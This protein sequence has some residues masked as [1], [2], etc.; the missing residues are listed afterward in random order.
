MTSKMKWS[1]ERKWNIDRYRWPLEL[2]PGMSQFKHRTF[3]YLP[4]LAG[5]TTQ[6]LN[7]VC[8][9]MTLL[10]NEIVSCSG[11]F[12][13]F[14]YSRPWVATPSPQFCPFS[15]GRPL[16]PF[17][18]SLTQA[19]ILTFLSSG[20]LCPTKS[21]PCADPSETHSCFGC[22][23]PI[24]ADQTGHFAG[25]VLQMRK[26]GDSLGLATTA[27]LWRM[28]ETLTSPRL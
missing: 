14:P 4:P 11:R 21:L 27:C 24:A 10:K 20:Y 6:I 26:K 28:K 16:R 9:I 15:K 7:M 22:P 13:N 5:G 2:Y 3:I 23:P 17:I 18:F 19:R 8:F 1:I 25:P 12:H